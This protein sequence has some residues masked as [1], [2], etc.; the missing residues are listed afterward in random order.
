MEVKIESVFSILF[1]GEF[2]HGP[3]E[4]DQSSESGSEKK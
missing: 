2:N 4:K 3:K 1:L